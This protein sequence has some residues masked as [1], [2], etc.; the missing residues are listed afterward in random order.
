MKERKKQANINTYI[1][2]TKH[3]VSV[4]CEILK[5]LKGQMSLS[6]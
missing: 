2:G 1:V 6:K 3:H 4:Q 5:Q